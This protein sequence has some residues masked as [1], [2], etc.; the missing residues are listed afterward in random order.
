MAEF[1]IDKYLSLL[2]LLCLIRLCGSVD[3]NCDYLDTSRKD[4]TNH[5]KCPNYGCCGDFKNRHCCVG[6]IPIV[7]GV[8]GSL[9]FILVV[10]V[11]IGV[12]CTHYKKKHRTQPVPTITAEMYNDI[13]LPSPPSHAPL[14][15]NPSRLH[16][17]PLVTH[18]FRHVKP[19]ECQQNHPPPSNLHPPR[20][21]ALRA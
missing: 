21:K 15:Y 14:V 17:P 19:A 8:F 18:P 1:K 13:P 6:P 3:E 9:L 7:A 12:C 5:L 16:P 20:L 4:R 10:A 11:I 2:C